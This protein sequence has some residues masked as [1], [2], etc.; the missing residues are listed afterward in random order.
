MDFKPQTSLFPEKGIRLVEVEVKGQER[1]LLLT[2]Y[3]KSK[4]IVGR[5][6][7]YSIFIDGVQAGVIGFTSVSAVMGSAFNVLYKGKKIMDGK[8]KSAWCIWYFEECINNNI[9]RLEGK[10]PANTASSVLAVARKQVYS[11]W[12]NKY[13]VHIRGIISL[14]YGGNEKGF[15]RMGTCYEADNWKYLGMTK[16]KKRILLSMKTGESKYVPTEKKH[17]W[18]WE[19]PEWKIPQKRG[20]IVEPCKSLVVIKC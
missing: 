8:K 17:I 1:E 20:L 5:R 18:L 7:Y 14:T 12:W 19:Y 3:P 13:K 9:F 6:C 11:D 2:H 4:G 16:G 15:R 10:F